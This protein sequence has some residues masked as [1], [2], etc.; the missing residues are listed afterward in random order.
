MVKSKFTIN[1][2]PTNIKDI[3]TDDTYYRNY[4]DETERKY[5]YNGVSE[6]E[7][8]VLNYLVKFDQDNGADKEY[9]GTSKYSTWTEKLE[10]VG[11][12]DIRNFVFYVNGLP[13]LYSE[14][15][16]TERDIKSIVAE[17][18]YYGSNTGVT[19]RRP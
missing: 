4:R 15:D 19:K 17:A 8:T 9:T 3:I 6:R 7:A 2:A 5:N 10:H 11:E 16:I 18:R 12:D 13:D 14:L 1:D